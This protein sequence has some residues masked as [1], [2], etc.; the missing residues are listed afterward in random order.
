M[1]SPLAA[2]LGEINNNCYFSDPTYGFDGVAVFG[3]LLDFSHSW[4][5]DV[6]FLRAV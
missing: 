1:V 2:L 6:V 3:F 5:F 4:R